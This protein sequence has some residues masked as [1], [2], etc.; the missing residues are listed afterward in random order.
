[1]RFLGDVVSWFAAGEHWRGADGIPHRL[2]EHLLMSGAA[3]LAALVLALPAGVVLGHLRRGGVAIVNLANVGRAIPSFALLVLA[4][5][6]FGIGPEPVFLTLLALG[7]PPIVT[8]AYVGVSE[9]DADAR[10]VARGMGMTGGQVLRH[11]EIPLALPLVMAGV[12]TAGVQVVA[13]ATLGAVIAWGGLGRYIVD[14]FAQ[15]DNVKIFCGALLVAGLS[16]GVEIGLAFLQRL[17]LSPGITGRRTTMAVASAVPGA[18]AHAS[19]SPAV[20]N[21]RKEQTHAET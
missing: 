14:G 10:E 1:M 17:T 19:L 6:V 18:A 12:R 15:Q 13:T 9:V 16:V 21:E 11:V 7:I 8:N 5:F 4:Y 3:V 2:T 20:L